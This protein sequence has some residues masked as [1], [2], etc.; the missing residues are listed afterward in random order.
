MSYSFYG[1]GSRT[2]LK[3]NCTAKRILEFI[4][5][6]GGIS[7]MHCKSLGIK[8]TMEGSLWSLYRRNYVK[9]FD[10]QTNEGFIYYLDAS[11]GFQYGLNRGLIPITVRILYERIEKNGA[12]SSLELRDLGIAQQ[13]IN[14]FYQKLVRARIIKSAMHGKYLV[15][16]N[17]EDKLNSYLKDYSTCL[18]NLE[19]RYVRK[20]KR[21]GQELE[22][23]VAKYYSSI[24][25]NVETNKFF[26]NSFGEHVEIDV[27][28]SRPEISLT[29][30]IE[31]KNYESSVLGPSILLKISRIK[32]VLPRAIVH[33]Y[34]KHISNQFFKNKAFFHDEKYRDTFLFSTKQIHEMFEKLNLPKVT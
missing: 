24:G 23:M 2:F 34:A 29:I 5:L 25:F 20:A 9:R 18:D 1:K 13:D 32:S 30:A 11:Q 33:I 19:A 22:R 28:A 6:N 31:C 16:Y 21:Q 15:F 10:F 4:K 3:R 7:A 12:V 14:W 8:R 17:S 27:L 26:T